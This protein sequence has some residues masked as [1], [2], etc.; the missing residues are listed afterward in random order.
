MLRRREIK[1]KYVTRY[2]KGEIRPER[3]I[4]LNWGDDF[5]LFIEHENKSFKVFAYCND[6]GWKQRGLWCCFGVQKKN[7][8]FRVSETEKAENTPK[9]STKVFIHISVYT[10]CG[11]VGWMSLALCISQL[12]LY[13]WGF[14]CFVLLSPLLASACKKVPC[15]EHGRVCKYDAQTRQVDLHV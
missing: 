2:H 12:T 11:F 4:K 3:K 13:K 5:P 9:E 14:N 7:L 10:T 6:C 15:T 8:V 1:K